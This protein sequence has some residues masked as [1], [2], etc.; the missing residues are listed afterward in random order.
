MCLWFG[1]LAIYILVQLSVEKGRACCSILE[2][3]FIYVGFKNPWKTNCRHHHSLLPLLFHSLSTH[4][5]KLYCFPS[6]V[7]HIVLDFYFKFSV[8]VFER[9]TCS[10][11]WLTPHML[12]TFRAWA[13]PKAKRPEP[14][15]DFLSGWQGP[16]YLDLLL[17]PFHGVT[18]ITRKLNCK[19]STSI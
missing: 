7:L 15:W 4:L 12:V 9:E 17:L 10:I 14:Q 11:H 18:F 6:I 19:Q 5:L 2:G 1:L 13:K 16:A 8:I 3:Y